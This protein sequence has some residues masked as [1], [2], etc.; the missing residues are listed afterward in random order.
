VI[1]AAQE[2]SDED[3]KRCLDVLKTSE[4]RFSL[5]TD[6]IAFAKADNEYS[7]N[8]KQTIE[9]M[10]KYLGINQQQF[11]LL[12]HFTDKSKEALD[13]AQTNPQAQSLAQSNSAAQP[14]AQSTDFLSSLGLK[15]KFESAGINGGSLLKGIL[16]M[17]APMILAKMV[18]G[19]LNRN[20]DL[21]VV[22][23]CLAVEVECLVAV[24]EAC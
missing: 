7:A 6:L 9:S 22:A 18:T 24:A 12:D 17:A 8:E 14:Q 13:A 19:G 2:I 10:A 23:V 15:D 21:V 5:V 20:R 11:G 3:T 4:L 1:R 16:G